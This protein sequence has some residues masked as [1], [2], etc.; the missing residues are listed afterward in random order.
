[1]AHFFFHLVSPGHYDKDD[2]GSDLPDVEAAYL[3]AHQAAI[4]MIPEMLNDR[5]DPG[6]FQFEITDAE[7]RFLMEL[8]FSEVMRPKVR[9][10]R[11]GGIRPLL[12]LHIEHGRRLQAEIRTELE[13]SRSVLAISRATLERSRAR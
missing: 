13:K 5:R 12:Q 1:M 11:P 8:P 3:E 4:E 6:Q 9:S 7:D 10:A 2:I